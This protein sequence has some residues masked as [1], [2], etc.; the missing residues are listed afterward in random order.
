M[1]SLVHLAL[2]GWIN[3]DLFAEKIQHSIECVLSHSPVVLFMYSH[4]SHITP[5]ILSKASDIGIHFVTFP[6]HT[7][8]MLQPLDVGVH[9]PLKEEIF[10]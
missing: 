5:E 1:A 2:K 6:S 3:S 7:M 10:D 9:K 4:A 8:N